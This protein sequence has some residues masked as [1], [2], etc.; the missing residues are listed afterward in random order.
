VIPLYHIGKNCQK[1]PFQGTEI[2][3][4][5]KTNGSI[6]SWKTKGRTGKLLAHR[7]HSGR[8]GVYKTILVTKSR[9]AKALLSGVVKSSG[10][11][12]KI[13]WICRVKW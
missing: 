7:V 8:K 6:Y 9:P 1:Y 3:R 11:G 5:D 13:L 4:K 12:D 10:A 2:D